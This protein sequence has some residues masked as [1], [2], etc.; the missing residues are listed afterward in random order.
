M[1]GYLYN[2]YQNLA[3]W[4]PMP[5]AGSARQ[6]ENPSSTATFNLEDLVPVYDP[7]NGKSQRAKYYNQLAYYRLRASHWLYLSFTPIGS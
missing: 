2:L 7:A 5:V 3:T 4:H 6:R 1:K